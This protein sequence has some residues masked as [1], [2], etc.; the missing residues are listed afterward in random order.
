MTSSEEENPRGPTVKFTATRDDGTEHSIVLPAPTSMVRT[1]AYVSVS[2]ELAH[3]DAVVEMMSSM[4]DDQEAR[5]EHFAEYQRPDDPALREAI[6]RGDVVEVMSE[7]HFYRRPDTERS[8]IRILP[9]EASGAETLG[10]LVRKGPSYIKQTLRL[11]ARKQ[12]E[13]E[14]LLR[15][16]IEDHVRRQRH[17]AQFAFDVFLSY[18]VRDSTIAESVQAKLV[19]SD[20]RVFM[21]PKELTPGDDFEEKIRHALRG[22]REVWVVVSPSSLGSEWV[23]TE[24]GAA[25]VLG[26]RIVPI[27]HRCDVPS[28]PGRL[29][30]VQCVD[31]ADIDA[32]VASRVS[33]RQT[34][35]PGR[36][37]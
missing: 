25:W 37:A 35:P 30:R 18:S 22:S 14:A 10:E 27:L 4:F 21:A 28:L 3:D 24:W 11:S 17:E 15:I 33:A 29:R 26:R 13:Y 8:F 23:T 2:G 32:L 20:T 19:A 5:F 36:G 12:L 31:A 1:R 16:D 34:P 7:P 9:H 6:D